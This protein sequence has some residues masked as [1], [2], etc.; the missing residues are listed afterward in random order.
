VPDGKK[1]L[2]SKNLWNFS[3]NLK[4]NTLIYRVYIVVDFGT[5]PGG[6]WQKPLHGEVDYG[7]NMVDFGTQ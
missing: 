2:F 1:L 4:K 7:T 3:E 6:L 5:R